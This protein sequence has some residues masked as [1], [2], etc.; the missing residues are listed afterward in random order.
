MILKGEFINFPLYLLL[1]IY[2]LIVY[3]RFILWYVGSEEKNEDTH[4]CH[5]QNNHLSFAPNGLDNLAL[6]ANG[7]AD[8]ADDNESFAS[9]RKVYRTAREEFFKDFIQDGTNPSNSPN[10]NNHMRSN[11]P[12]TSKYPTKVRVAGKTML[13]SVKDPELEPKKFGSLSTLTELKTKHRNS[14]ISQPFSDIVNTTFPQD[15]SSPPCI[16]VQDNKNIGSISTY[17][18]HTNYNSLKKRKQVKTANLPNLLRWTKPQL[19]DLSINY[20]IM[21][22]S[23]YF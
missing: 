15:L 5:G 3:Q 20:Y 17:H 10:L 9:R 23:A 12:D 13:T 14:P 8:I 18:N 19:L 21:Y 1:I 2:F 16:T 4:N 6:N 7:N 11:L 22:Y